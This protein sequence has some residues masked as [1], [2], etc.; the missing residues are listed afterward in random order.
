MPIKWPENLH[1]KY[2]VCYP[3]N[4]G[5]STW[6]CESDLVFVRKQPYAVLHWTRDENGETPDA[7]LP[8]NRRLLKHDRAEDPV[9]RYEGELVDPQQG[10]TKDS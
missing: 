10:V 5:G 1:P 9:F 8:L 6:L 4:T 3:L 2:R 7:W